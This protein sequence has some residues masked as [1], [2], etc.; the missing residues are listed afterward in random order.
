M[1]PG[2]SNGENIP[3]AILQRCGVKVMGREIAWKKT[4]RLGYIAQHV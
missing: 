3:L 4:T 2:Y 1:K